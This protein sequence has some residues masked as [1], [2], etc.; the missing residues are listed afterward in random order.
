[1]EYGVRLLEPFFNHL[2]NT[3]RKDAERIEVE[4]ATALKRGGY[5]VEGGH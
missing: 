5:W 1:M 2:Q 4:L 3:S